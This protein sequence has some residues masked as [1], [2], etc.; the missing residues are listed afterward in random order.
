MRLGI[1]LEDVETPALVVLRRAGGGSVGGLFP[2]LPGQTERLL[3]IPRQKR[4][5]EQLIHGFFRPVKLGIH[6]KGSL[7][8]HDG[9][10]VAPVLGELVGEAEEGRLVVRVG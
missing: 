4:G 10:S 6:E 7:V 5:V 2:C 9:L 1:V 3:E 8:F